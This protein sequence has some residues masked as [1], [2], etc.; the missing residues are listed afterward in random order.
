M[1]KLDVDPAL[2]GFEAF[3]TSQLHEIS[4]RRIE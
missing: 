2:F 4:S 3:R 1:E